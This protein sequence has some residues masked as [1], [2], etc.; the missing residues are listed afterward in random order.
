[1]APSENVVGTVYFGA[2]RKSYGSRSD[3]NNN[4]QNCDMIAWRQT[5][6]IIGWIIEDLSGFLDFELLWQSFELLCE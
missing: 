2:R 4:A 5:V 1:M 6:D 3:T